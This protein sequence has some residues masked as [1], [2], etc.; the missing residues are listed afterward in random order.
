MVDRVDQNEESGDDFFD[1]PTDGGEGIGLDTAE[2]VDYPALR[3]FTVISEEQCI[4]L[5]DLSRRFEA[6]LVR[7]LGISVQHQ[8]DF[9]VAK[10]ILNEP[11]RGR[12]I[13]ELAGFSPIESNVI[14]VE[15]T[16]GVDLPAVCSPLLTAELGIL[17]LY[18][19]L[20]PPRVNPVVAIS[21]ENV[22][23]A[24]S[25]LHQQG[26]RLLDEGDFLT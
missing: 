19:L 7:V 4:F 26:F 10:L 11:E 16:E 15:L 1:A 5:L 13:L 14:A 8:S 21:L 9:T 25:V 22:E 17:H 24:I 23:L 3:Q 18:P 20:E 2:E 12:E 6:S